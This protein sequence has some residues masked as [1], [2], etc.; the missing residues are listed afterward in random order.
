MDE[1]PKDFNCSMTWLYSGD[2]CNDIDTSTIDKE[3]VQKRTDLKWEMKM[4]QLARLYLMAARFGCPLLQTAA[5]H[6]IL[7]WY[8]GGEMPHLN[9]LKLVWSAPEEDS[10][11]LRRA[12][13]D[14]CAVTYDRVKPAQIP[15][16]ENAS[17]WKLLALRSLDSRHDPNKFNEKFAHDLCEYHLYGANANGL[18]ELVECKE[19]PNGNGMYDACTQQMQSMR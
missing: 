8:T 5:I 19:E 2:I 16:F 11:M 15:D 17:F 9:L 10:K 7:D 1:D 14:A 13:A 12:L 18:A 3:N 4:E 6:A